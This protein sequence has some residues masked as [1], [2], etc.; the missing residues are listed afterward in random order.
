MN[1]NQ[2]QEEETTKTTSSASDDKEEETKPKTRTKKTTKPNDKVDWGTYY[3]PKSIFC[4]EYDCYKILGFDYE[5][6]NAKAKRGEKIP[7]S[8]ITKTYRKLSREWHPDKNKSNPKAK[9]R[10][11]KIAR[12]YE[13]LTN[14]KTRK[15]YDFMRYN[16]EAYVSKYGSSVLWQYAPKSDTIFVIIFLLTCATA[17]SWYAQYGKWSNVAYRLINAAVD[18]LG[19]QDGGTDESKA[20]RQRAIDKLKEDE[21][22]GGDWVDVDKP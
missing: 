16:Q 21:K 2:P 22:N 1:K 7:R 15:E 4:G 3:D 13:V 20:L 19:K 14:E 11:V 5:D 9:E 17:I 6:F 8:E 12:A 10:F 18:D